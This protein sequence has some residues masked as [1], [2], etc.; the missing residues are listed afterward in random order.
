MALVDVEFRGPGTRLAV[1]VRGKQ[2]PVVVCP[3]PFVPQR[4][5]RG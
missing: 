3:M 5:F 4:Y 2:L 1:D